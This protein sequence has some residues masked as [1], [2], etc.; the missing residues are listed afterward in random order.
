MK[1]GWIIVSALLVIIIIGVVIL[2]VVPANTAN[3]PTN[4]GTTPTTTPVTTTPPVTDNSAAL[5]DTIVV[6]SPAPNATITSP[7]TITGKARGSFYFEASFP[8]KL[9][10][11]FGTTLAQG[12]AKAPTQLIGPSFHMPGHA[13]CS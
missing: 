10:D 6:N 9:V 7:L 4:K 12:T 1:K 5:T 3:A 11:A 2:V 8:V 13:S